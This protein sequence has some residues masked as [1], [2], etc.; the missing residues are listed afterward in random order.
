MMSLRLFLTARATAL[1]LPSLTSSTLSALKC[2][3]CCQ[4][5][6]LNSRVITNPN[7]LIC[8]YNTPVVSNTLCKRYFSS[9]LHISNNIILHESPLLITNSRSWKIQSL[10]LRPYSSRSNEQTDDTSDRFNF[11]NPRARGVTEYPWWHR[12]LVVGGVVA[13]VYFIW[14]DVENNKELEEERTRYEEL[15]VKT[16]LG[17]EWIL[18]D[19]N[20]NKRSSREFKGH[21]MLIYFGFTHCPDI[22]PE[23]MEKMNKIVNT[24]DKKTKL[25]NLQP[26]FITLDPERDSP[27]VIKEYLKDF[28]TPRIVGF[29]AKTEDE[30]RDVAKKFRVYFGKGQPDEDNDYII[31]HTIILYLV[32]S[33][34]KFVNYYGRGLD[35]NSVIQSIEKHMTKYKLLKEKKM[36]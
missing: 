11:Q 25:P 20:G 12:L 14:K 16:P 30:I 9:K 18:T 2:G 13:L 3:S 1:S 24:I 15:N 33:E 21:W 26:I 4:G 22:C 5:C 7:R 19:D 8:I 34:G 10:S 27:K 32:N 36:M 31:D 28:K 23:E 35:A 17:G 29:T 6:V